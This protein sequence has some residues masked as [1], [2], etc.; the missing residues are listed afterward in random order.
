[1]GTRVDYG[2]ARSRKFGHKRYGQDFT[3]KGLFPQFMSNPM[4]KINLIGHSLG[5]PTGRMFAHLIRYGY[6]EEVKASKAAGTTVSPLFYTNR[7][8]N[9]VNSFMSIA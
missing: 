1:M 7:T 4:A 9:F 2:V 8:T 6:E 5:G 3:G